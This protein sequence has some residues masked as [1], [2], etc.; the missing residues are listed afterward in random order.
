MTKEIH[1]VG[2]PDRVDSS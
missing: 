2:P 1:K